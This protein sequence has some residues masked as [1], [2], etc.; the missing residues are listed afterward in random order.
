MIDYEVNDVQKTL[1][2]EN[3]IYHHDGEEQLL[4]YYK[5]L[6]EL[7][8]LKSEDYALVYLTIHK[9]KPTANSIPLL[10]YNSLCS[11]G[12]LFCIGY[13]DDVAPW[14]MACI[15]KVSSER[16]RGLLKQYIETINT[17]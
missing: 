14:L 10:L 13:K 17:L 16:V 12:N 1:V 8:R 5:Y 6:T 7:R 3:K 15:G 4:R 11:T 9:S 2:I